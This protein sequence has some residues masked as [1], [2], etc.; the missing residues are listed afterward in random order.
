MDNCL[1]TSFY[2]K[3]Y[4]DIFNLSDSEAKKHWAKIGKKEGRLPNKILFEEKYPNFNDKEWIK[5]NT[6]YLFDTK[7]E[8]YGWVY[9][10]NKKNYEKYLLDNN[11][12]KIEQKETNLIEEPNIVEQTNIKKINNNVGLINL[13]SKYNIKVSNVSKALEHFEPR[14]LN[15]FNLVKYNPETDSTNPVIFFG[16]YDHH[17]FKKVVEHQGL[18]F[19]IWGGTDC[20]DRYKIRKNSIYVIKKIT[21]LR[22]IAISKCIQER[23][24]KY[25]IESE[26]IDFSLI[27]ENLFKPVEKLGDS[28]YIYNGFSKGNEYIYGEN[29]Y[30]KVVEMLPDFKFILSNELN[31]S[32]ETM[33]SIYANCFIGL[34]L[35]DG[36]GNANT[37]QEFNAMGIPIIFNGEN[38]IPW[39][40]EIDIIENINKYYNNF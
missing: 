25:E 22:H 39:T 33:P 37:V 9:I 4:K 21:K 30:K 24:S 14:Y 18:K 27:D 12:I 28:I 17:D 23:L 34:R 3:C 15:K 2:K 40:N 11:F 32:W 31:V 1:F 10:Q 38:G 16:L 6:K 26:L 8:I 20:D 36:D 13:I 19:L 7:Y 35:T 29:I 5:N